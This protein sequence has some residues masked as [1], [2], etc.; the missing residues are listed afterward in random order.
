V[1]RLREI[2]GA[3]S[4]GGARKISD[5]RLARIL[6]PSRLARSKL[7]VNVVN[8][9]G[10]GVAALGNRQVTCLFKRERARARATAR[11]I[12]DY[13]TISWRLLARRGKSARRKAP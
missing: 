12:R 9:F 10:D 8:S 1:K 3:S 4:D 7:A 6:S 2:S 13:L 11:N 5:V